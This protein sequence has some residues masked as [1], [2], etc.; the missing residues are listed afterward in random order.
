M[1]NIEVN[2]D[3]RE[4]VTR[5][6]TEDRRDDTAADIS[7]YSISRKAEKGYRDIS[8]GFDVVPGQNYWLLWADYDT[9]DSFGRDGNKVEFIDLFQ[10]PDRAA[11]AAKELEDVRD[12]SAKY[13]RED[14]TKIKMYI[15]WVGYF[16]SLNSLNITMVGCVS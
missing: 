15:P 14:G 2:Y 7:V 12:F 4:Y 3:R 5:R 1:T 9:G 11:A 6:A 10:S 13:T 8:V 16:E